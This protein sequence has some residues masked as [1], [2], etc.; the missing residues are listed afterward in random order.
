MEED[1][2]T[3]EVELRLDERIENHL[4]DEDASYRAI[5]GS[6]ADPTAPADDGSLSLRPLEAVVLRAD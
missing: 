5:G 2:E 4:P 3:G 1:A 6:H